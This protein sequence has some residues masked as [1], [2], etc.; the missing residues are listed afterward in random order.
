VLELELQEAQMIPNNMA[1][2]VQYFFE[3]DFIGVANLRMD[4][5]H[6]IKKYS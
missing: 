2:T 6:L 1:K 3:S 4:S 5:K